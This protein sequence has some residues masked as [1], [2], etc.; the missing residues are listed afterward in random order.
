MED[1][2]QSKLDNTGL[3]VQPEQMLREIIAREPEGFHA[4]ADLGSLLFRLN[5]PDEAMALFN[6]TISKYPDH[7]WPLSIKAAVLTAERRA[8]EALDAHMA[9][10]NR[11]PHAGLPWI[12]YADA[13]KT[14]GRTTEAVTAYRKAVDLDPCNGSAWWGLANL[15]TISLTPG[16]VALMEQVLGQAR[17]KGGGDPFQLIQLQ[18]ALGKALADLG[19]YERSFQYY[20]KANR[21]RGEYAPFDAEAMHDFI[22]AS[23][24]TFTPE[25]F[26]Q[27]SGSGHDAGN[28]I[29]IVG[30]PRSGSTLIE[31]I[32]ASHPMVEGGGELFELGE[33]ANNI[34][35]R[36]SGLTSL[37][38][39]ISGLNA[40]ELQEIGKAYLDSVHRH[41]RTNR[42]YFTD[43]MPANW[44]FAPLIH[45]IL[46]N[47]KII[48]VRR[49]PSACCFS[50]FTTYFNRQTSFPADLTGLA[51]YYRDYVRMTAH[52]DAALPG[53]ILRVQYEQIV[54]DIDTEVRCLLD[55][56][57]LPFDPA[58]LYYYEN[59]RPVHTPSAQQVRRPINRD[60]LHHWRNYSQW[61][62]PLHGEWDSD[63]GLTLLPFY[64][65]WA[66]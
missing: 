22:R 8:D 19:D 14:V 51:R 15:R 52:M 40:G 62:A 47:A 17:T 43:K 27:H 65:P 54:E 23:T 34:A 58:C 33:I 4:Y 66:E 10:L 60:G 11:A 49:H 25:F 13:L 42:P 39:V 21:L 50:A 28:I 5:R 59:K 12:N 56:L 26:A 6:E 1:F 35:L 41:R 31:Q 46:P 32:L 38:K 29:F 36:G 24:A 61:L 3:A 2:R 63:N 44:R 16:D 18:F 45:L 7:V 55:W 64:G 20:T 30:M 53:R 57:D 37:P 9:V 48:D